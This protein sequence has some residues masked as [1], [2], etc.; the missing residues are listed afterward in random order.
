ME[1]CHIAID[2]SERQNIFCNELHQLNV[3]C[4]FAAM[5]FAFSVLD[6]NT[7]HSCSW[8][9]HNKFKLSAPCRLKHAQILDF[10]QHAHF[11]VNKNVG[12]SLFSVSLPKERYKLREASTLNA[13][14][15]VLF[16]TGLDLVHLTLRGLIRK[17]LCHAQLDY[18]RMHQTEIKI[19]N[20]C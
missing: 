9:Y 16:S 18:R 8:K 6:S 14:G 2:T 19:H 17:A 3:P 1:W 20:N 12:E 5:S 10:I 4:N 7:K 13:V 15:R 11:A